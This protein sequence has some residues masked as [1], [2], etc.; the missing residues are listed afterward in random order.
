MNTTLPKAAV[1]INT[2]LITLIFGNYL[3][4]DNHRSAKEPRVCHPAGP[5]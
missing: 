1:R 2:E 4:P 3:T 5:N